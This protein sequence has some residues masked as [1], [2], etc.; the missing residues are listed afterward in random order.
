VAAL[1]GATCIAFSGVF[2]LFAAVSPSTGTFYRAFF[3]LPLLVLVAVLEWRRYGPLPRDAVRLAAIAAIFFTG[4]LMFWHHAIEAVGAGLGTVLGNLQVIIVG[5]VAWMLLG[6]RPSRA[7]MLA[8][9]I[10][11]VGVVLISGV[12]GA[13]AYGSNPQLGV[14]LGLLT[15][16]CYAA[17][18]LTIRRGGRDGRRPAGPVAI[19]TGIVVICSFVIGRVV[20][21]LDLTPGPPSIF[22]LVMLG[23]TSQSA[24]Y[25]LISVSLPRLPAI[26]TSVILLC[27]PV[28]S[29]A[30]AMVLLG[31]SPSSTQLLGVA[32]VVGGIT[33][34][35]I[36]VARMRDGLQ[37]LRSPS[38]A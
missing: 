4:D 28:M 24:G 3:G 38:A 15:A 9:P 1:L 5:L 29:M 37:R 31:E 30:L 11:L 16:V 22:W 14:I 12:V 32:F 23:V 7:T 21:D 17:Y 6:E 8:L 20:G 35:T 36:P 2:Y 33:A 10:V 19:A 26:I 13:G 25:L 18:L 34:A 27:Q